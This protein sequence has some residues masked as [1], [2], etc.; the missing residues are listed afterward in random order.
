MANATGQQRMTGPA[1]TS[2][3]ESFGYGYF[4]DPAGLG[5]RGYRRDGNGDG[6]YLPWIAAREFCLAHRVKSA[7]DIGCAKGFLVAELLGAGIDAAGYDVS[8]YALSF[9]NGLPCYQAD[10]RDGV[11][12]TAEAVFALGVLLYLDETE[13]PGVLADLHRHATRFLLFSSY[14]E[15][16]EQDIPDP[17]RRITRPHE[18]WRAV[19]ATTGF[20]FS[21]RGEC[22]DVYTA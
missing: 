8:S 2:A 5:Y 1:A 15:G 21:H 14:Y 9:A 19:L 11:L 13:L 20:S 10:V 4:D 7:V 17:L 3:G 12:R 16:D 6:G 22:F 18:W